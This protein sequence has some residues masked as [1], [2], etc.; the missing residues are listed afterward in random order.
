MSGVFFWRRASVGVVS[1]LL[2]DADGVSIEGFVS[3]ILCLAMAATSH[4]LNK[5]LLEVH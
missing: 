5:K 3:S 4:P 2:S 1:S